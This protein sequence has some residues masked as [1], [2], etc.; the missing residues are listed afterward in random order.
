M[1]ASNLNIVYI[2]FLCIYPCLHDWSYSRH[3]KY[4]LNSSPYNLT[5]PAQDLCTSAAPW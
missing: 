3:D 4:T 1:Q 2:L 5:L